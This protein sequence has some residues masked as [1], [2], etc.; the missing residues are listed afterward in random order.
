MPSEFLKYVDRKT[1][2]YITTMLVTERRAYKNK[3]PE[4]L[5]TFF[6]IQNSLSSSSI[7]DVSYSHKLWLLCE[8]L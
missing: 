1:T 3:G 2:N 4:P 6:G 7:T 8:Q 5:R